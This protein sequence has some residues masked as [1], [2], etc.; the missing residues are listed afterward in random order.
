MRGSP[1]QADP[2]NDP[3]SSW[4]P[5]PNR[6]R[7]HPLADTA[8]IVSTVINAPSPLGIAAA[9]AR[10]EASGI[11]SSTFLTAG[12]LLELLSSV[13]ANHDLL[14][15]WVP[16]SEI[17]DVLAF[18]ITQIEEAVR[19][20]ARCDAWVNADD[21]ARMLGVSPS[22]ITSRIRR[23]TLSAERRGRRWWINKNAL[24]EVVGG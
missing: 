13:I 22:T 4:V 10:L 16:R 24:N 11:H 1:K 6:R 5:F 21:A 8:A 15:V 18:M 20:A 14:R 2:L 3:T 19:A 9:V 23:G 17:A 12:P 7:L